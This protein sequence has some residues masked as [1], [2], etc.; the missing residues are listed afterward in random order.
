MGPLEIFVIRLL[1]A[2]LFSV[3]IGRF[4]FHG[5]PVVK[6]SALAVVMLALAYL[7]EYLRKRKRGGNHG[8]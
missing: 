2:G 5:T 7:L 1:L 6:V 4:F 3:I 8:G